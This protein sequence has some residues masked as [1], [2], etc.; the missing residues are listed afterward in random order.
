VGAGCAARGQLS[1]CCCECW[2]AASLD[3]S[4]SWLVPYLLMVIELAFSGQ[5]PVNPAYN[6]TQQHDNSSLSLSDAFA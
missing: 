2:P 4:R 5:K 1:A 3:S 6:I